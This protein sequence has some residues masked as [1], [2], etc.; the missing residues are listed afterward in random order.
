MGMGSPW[1]D[2]IDVGYNHGTGLGTG[3]GTGLGTGVTRGPPPAGGRSSGERMPLSAAA[4]E[5]ESILQGMRQAANNPATL[6]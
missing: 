5:M 6:F 1:R 3:V 4:M 2:D